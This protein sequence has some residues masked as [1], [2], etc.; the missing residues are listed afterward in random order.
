MRDVYATRVEHVPFE[1]AAQETISIRDK[2]ASSTMT[3][4][5]KKA[6]EGLLSLS[7]QK[8]SLA[9]G[10]EKDILNEVLNEA[11][12]QREKRAGL[13]AKP[14]PEVLK[15]MQEN[16][17]EDRNAA[18]R[19]LLEGAVEKDLE[20]VK[21]AFS[22]A[23]TDVELWKILH[24]R[25][26]ARV[27]PLD[28]DN[29]TP[30]PAAKPKKRK[31]KANQDTTSAT[32]ATPQWPGDIPDQLVITET[33]PQHLIACQRQLFYDFPSSHLATSLLPY[34]KSLGPTTFALAASTE[35]YNLHMRVLRQAGNF[36]AVISTLEEMDK[37]VYDF[38]DR[39]QDTMA[40][41][42]KRAK[43]ARTGIYGPGVAALWNGQR[44]RKTT[45][46]LSSWNSMISSRMQ[47]KALREARAKEEEEAG[48]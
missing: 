23:Q 24:D 9:K 8:N 40:A 7:Q 33:L 43:P 48:K 3:P 1:Y 12:S 27:K 13:D 28:L 4:S 36:Q 29:P 26:L 21:E 47:E 19:V 35:L 10:K 42:L 41:I 37:E 22:A 38:D 31:A 17:R 2:L 18:Q 11:A 44:S 32:N 45:K 25:V 34:L 15:K 6:F 46:V 30:K 39:T 20:Q 14:I 5:E 16:M